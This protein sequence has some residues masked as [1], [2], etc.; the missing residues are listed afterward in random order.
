MYDSVNAVD[1]PV[2]A[3]MVAGYVNGTYKWSDD[4]W[5]RFPHAVKVRIATRADVDD[6]HVLDV[7]KGAAGVNQAP[8]WV[9]MRRKHG[10]TP[11][12]YCSA[13]AWAAVRRQFTVYN[14]DEPYWWIAH[15]DNVPIIPSG[16]IAKQYINP[17]ASGG[18]YDVSVVAD[19]WPGVDGDSAMTN[20]WDE[21]LT[22]SPGGQAKS[23]TYPAAVWLT[24]TNFYANQ[25]PD[26]VKKVDVLTAAVDALTTQLDTLI[27]QGVALS[28][29]GEIRV[30]VKPPQ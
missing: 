15:Y 19:S 27:G 30:G 3:V 14:V 1:I 2:R 12:V 24:Y 4:D 20:V 7:E 28:A 9:T 16:A 8:G 23:I 11:T 13:S 17:P 22:L 10:I 26:L 18:H 6:G 25:I 29:V 21:P 5:A